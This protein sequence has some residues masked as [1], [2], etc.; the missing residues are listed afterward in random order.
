VSG[1]FPSAV[2]REVNERIAEI[3]AGW[4]WAGAQGFMCE[5][6]REGCTQVVLLT[7]EQYL[8]VRSST[9][10]FVI[11]PGHEQPSARV[12]ESHEQFVVVEL[13]V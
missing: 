11:A 7:R 10:R 12:V 8:A 9:G 6:A 3:T 4:T 5:C 1:D 13:S 2:F